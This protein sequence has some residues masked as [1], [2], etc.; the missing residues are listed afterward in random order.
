[1]DAVGQTGT[2]VGGQVVLITQTGANTGGAVITTDKDDYPPGTP[3]I[4]TGTGFGAG[5]TVSLT[6]HEDPTLRSGPTFTATADANGGFVYSGF[7]PD[8]HDIDVRFVLTAKGQTSGEAGADD[9]HGCECRIRCRCGAPRRRS[10]PRR[11]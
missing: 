4:M 2:G 8:S 1:M 7:A 10:V 11:R 3:V 6:L 9:V 5:E